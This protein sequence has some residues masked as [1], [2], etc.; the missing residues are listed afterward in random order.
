[1]IDLRSGMTPQPAPK[2]HRMP[3][4]SLVT[5]KPSPILMAAGFICLIAAAFVLYRI[6]LIYQFVQLANVLMALAVALVT[7]GI[8]PVDVRNIAGE[9][10][11]PGGKIR[12]FGPIAVGLFMFILLTGTAA[13]HSNSPAEVGVY[14]VDND[15]QSSIQ[16]DG[17]RLT[18]VAT[19]TFASN[20]I[21]D[22][23]KVKKG[24]DYRLDSRP[25][26]ISSENGLCRFI[27]GVYGVRS[28]PRA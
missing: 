13:G 24:G 17:Q 25:K 19:E 28:Y 21:S 18:L 2:R 20:Q 7:Y 9:F 8:S 4:E 16:S 3:E 15:S 1:M 5:P 14:V 22:T 11:A 10:K 23:V 6:G 12:V 27:F 26:G